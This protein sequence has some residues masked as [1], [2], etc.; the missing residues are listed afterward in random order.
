[1]GVDVEIVTDEQRLRPV[2]SEV[3]RL[4]ASNE[5]AKRVLGWEPR[6]TGVDGLK[7]GLIETISWFRD[8]R[9]LTRYKSKQY[10]L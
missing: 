7:S 5:K 8:A 2:K 9:N 10:N 1:M 6:F 4:W 3:E